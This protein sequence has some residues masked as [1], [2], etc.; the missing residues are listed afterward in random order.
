MNFQDI[1]HSTIRFVLPILGILMML[2]GVIIAL[3]PQFKETKIWIFTFLP[4]NVRKHDE[5]RKTA[6]MLIGIGFILILTHYFIGDNRVTRGI[7]ARDWEGRWLINREWE[8]GIKYDFTSEYLALFKIEDD[9]LTATLH[10]NGAIPLVIEQPSN[11]DYSHIKGQ[12]ISADGNVFSTEFMMSDQD[13]GGRFLGRFQYKKGKIWKLL[14][15]K[16]VR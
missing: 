12:Y 14:I 1:I 9:R 11:D 8:E 2:F 10:I 6:F 7:E 5:A 4:R 16:K 13:D 3:L 15:G